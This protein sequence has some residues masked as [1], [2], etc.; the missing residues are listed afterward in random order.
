MGSLLPDRPDAVLCFNDLLALGALHA[1]ARHGL[2]VPE[3]VAV[4]GIDD[5]EDGRFSTPTLTTIAP[6]KAGV[7]REAVRLLHD[8]LESPTAG[9]RRVSVGFELLPRESTVGA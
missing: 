4:V 8:R 6:D 9:S 2:R 1:L 7:A 5:I 3:D